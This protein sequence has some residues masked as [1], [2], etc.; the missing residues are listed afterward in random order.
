MRVGRSLR[1][2]A[3]SAIVW[4]ILVVAPMGCQKSLAAIDDAY[5]T[6]EDVTLSVPVPGVL[7]NDRD[8][9][10]DALTAL[11]KSDPSSA[12]S[13]TLNT[14][15]SFDYTPAANFSGTD[16][17]TYKADDGNVESSETLVTITVN[18]TP[19]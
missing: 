3:A 13:F 10:G 4:A 15:G 17:F 18:S 11:L 9:E 8:P 5:S 7:G 16:S 14:D 2:P 6:D 12:A 1:G 19:L